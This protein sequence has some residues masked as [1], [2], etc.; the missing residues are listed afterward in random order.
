MFYISE[1]VLPVNKKQC[2]CKLVDCIHTTHQTAKNNLIKLSLSEDNFFMVRVGTCHARSAGQTHYFDICPDMKGI[3]IGDNMNILHEPSCDLDHLD[4]FLLRSLSVHVIIALFQI[5]H[6]QTYLLGHFTWP[7]SHATRLMWI[8]NWTIWNTLEKYLILLS[9]YCSYSVLSKAYLD[10]GM[11]TQEAGHFNQTNW[12]QLELTVGTWGI[13]TKWAKLPML[14]PAVLPIRYGLEGGGVSE[15]GPSSLPTRYRAGGDG[16]W[17]WAIQFTDQI[18]GWRGGSVRMGHPVYRPDTGL[19]GR[20]SENG[21]SSLPTR[22]RAGGEGQWEWAIQFTDQTLGWRGGSVRMGHPV[23]R[24]DTGLEGRVSENGPSSLPTRYRAGGEGQWE[25]AI[26]FTDQI[27]GWRG[28]SVRMGHPV[29][30]PD[31]GLEGKVSENGPSSLPTRYRAGGEGQWEWAIQFTDQILGWRGGSVRMG[32]PVYRPDTGLE[33]RVSENG[34]SSLP[35]RYRAGGEGQW[36]WAI[37]FTDQ[38]LGWGGGP[39]RMGHPVY[40]PD[41]GLEGRVSQNGPSSLPTRHWAGGEGQWEWAIQF[42]DQILGWRGGS[43][44]MGHPVYRPDTGLGGI[45]S[46]NGPSSWFIE[47]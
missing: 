18:Q 14:L 15:N 17:E 41:T 11:M 40:R 30:R 16:Q 9:M 7:V 42:T 45:V 23:Y 29:Y 22:Y 34:P 21:P 38:I 36:E 10:A 26:Q 12:G 1:F 25:W 46:E 5:A 27:Q 8:G 32:H 4:V 6:S 47:L 33:G 35:T 39:V 24:P 19:E 37:Q 31:T 2:P 13:L 3:Y 28:G 20:V 44:R 43:V